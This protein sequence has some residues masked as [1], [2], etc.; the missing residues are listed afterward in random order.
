MK[1]HSTKM[2][3]MLSLLIASGSVTARAQELID[4]TAIKADVPHAFIVKDK[5]L[6]A[7]KYTVKRLDDTQPNVLEIRS[8]DGRNAVTFEAESAQTNQIP[9]KAELVF[10]KLGDQYFLSKIWTADSSLGYQLP[11]TKA[12]ENL[13]G[14]GMKAEHHSIFAKVHKRTKKTT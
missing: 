11:K 3:L 1:I 9:R 2:L 13:E 8:E 4:D 7:G 14:S 5:T 10:S 12:E 6:P